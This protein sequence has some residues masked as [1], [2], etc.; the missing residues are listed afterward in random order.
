MQQEPDPVVEAWLDGLPAES[1]WTT[2]VTVFE[3]SL[4]LELLAAGKRRSV[5]EEAF[6]RA[7]AEDFED[8]VLSFD[9]GAA[10]VAGRIAAAQRRAGKTVEIRD[11]QIAAICAARKAML[12]TRNVR[13]FEGLGLTL[14][15][16]W[17]E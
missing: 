11:V 5:L 13:H 16:P 1:V 8:R 15:N 9:D 7:L 6:A 2:A 14:V 10:R 12:A 17:A 3:I 4:G